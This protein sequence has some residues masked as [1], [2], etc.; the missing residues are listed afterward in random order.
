MVRLRI[1]GYLPFV[2][3]SAWEWDE[4]RQQFYFYNFIK[5]QPDLN[6]HNTD[7]VDAIFERAE[8]W[9][10]KGV[11]GFRI[12]AP[13]YFYHDLQLRDNPPRPDD[14]SSTRRHSS[15][16]TQWCSSYLNIISVVPK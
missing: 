13:N 11:D 5:S 2:G 10:E 3:E 16:I 7:M 1:I 15:Q 4:T 6:W 8:F 14:A 12:D 9:L